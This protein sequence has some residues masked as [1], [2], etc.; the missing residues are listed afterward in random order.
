MR[1]REG[2]GSAQAEEEG[3]EPTK[4]WV[5]DLIDEIL[6]EEFASPDLELHWLE[7]EQGRSKG[8]RLLRRTRNCRSASNVKPKGER[9]NDA[10]KYQSTRLPDMVETPASGSQ[11]YLRCVNS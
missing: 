5:K 9:N 7:E 2:W 4:E 8:P 1:G 10:P 6:A 11:S 3:L